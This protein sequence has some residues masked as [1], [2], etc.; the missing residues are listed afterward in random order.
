[1]FLHCSIIDF[2]YKNKRDSLISSKEATV[3]ERLN[4]AMLK[5]SKPIK[6]ENYGKV[7]WGGSGYVHLVGMISKNIYCS[8]D[9]LYVGIKV[10]NDS[11]R[12]VKSILN[13]LGRRMLSSC[14]N[15][16]ATP[17]HSY[18]YCRSKASGLRWLGSC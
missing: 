6:L 12:T 9:N 5:I 10:R 4:K 2:E 14:S 8:G 7:F 17:T 15:P 13:C 18:K 11:R 3:L 1:M 16:I